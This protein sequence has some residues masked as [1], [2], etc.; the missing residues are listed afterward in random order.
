MKKINF[1]FLLFFGILLNA[2]IVSGKI[3]S[4]EEQT[5]ISYAKIGVENSN[6]GSIADKDGNFSIDLSKVDKNSNMKIE[7]AGFESYSV[8]VDN[9]IKKNEQTISLSEK[10][11]NIEEVKINPKKLVDKNWGVNSTTKKIQFSYNPSKNNS[12]LSKEIAI[13]LNSKKKAKIEKINFNIVYFKTDRPIF[14]RYNIYDEN[15]QSIV[16]EDVTTELDL[17]KIIN[18]T[19][20]IDVSDKNIWIKGKFYVSIQV[21]NYFEGS[22]SLSGT[23]F[24]PAIFRKYLGNWEKVPVVCPAINIDVKVLK[25]E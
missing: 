2:Q 14:I 22:L 8:L 15:L 21:L 23:P 24:K 19:F 20:A 12:D 16:N 25:N 4:N 10:I 18:N 1:L 3:I 17:Q 11:K 5:P 9:F 13:E 6:I 7:V